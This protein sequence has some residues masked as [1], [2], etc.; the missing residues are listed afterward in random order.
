MGDC[1]PPAFAMLVASS[2]TLRQSPRFCTLFFNN[3]QIFIFES[4]E[5]AIVQRSVFATSTQ[6]EDLLSKFPA[7]IAIN[8]RVFARNSA[9]TS[10]TQFQSLMLIADFQAIYP[11]F[12]EDVLSRKC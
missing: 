3:D 1:P 9:L 8:T 5:N 10:A 12:M 2:L 4:V 6:I 11:I 7:K